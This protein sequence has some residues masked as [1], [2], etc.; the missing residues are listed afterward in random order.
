[1]IFVIIP[2]LNLGTTTEDNHDINRSKRVSKT[3]VSLDHPLTP[4]SLA[5]AE[6]EPQTHHA[7][8]QDNQNV[9]PMSLS[10]RPSKPQVDSGPTYA[11]AAYMPGR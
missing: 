8:D 2:I 7:H 3:R 10:A 6:P 4:I 5:I 11:S 1:M 9:A